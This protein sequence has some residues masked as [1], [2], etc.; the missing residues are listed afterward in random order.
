[1]G[2]KRS[3]GEGSAIRRPR[4]L[5]RVAVRRAS[6]RRENLEARRPRRSDSPPRMPRASRWP[7]VAPAG[8]EHRRRRGL[9]STPVS[10]GRS[11]ASTITTSELGWWWGAS[12]DR[13][14]AFERARTGGGASWPLSSRALAGKGRSIPKRLEESVRRRELAATGT[15]AE[16][17]REAAQAMNTGQASPAGT[18]PAHGFA[19][20]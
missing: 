14:A 1:V 2:G 11:R 4:R 13:Q 17:N 10:I 7:R 5:C 20:C 15:T 16:T 9:P 3:L 8:P 19:S 18:S 12:P 6:R